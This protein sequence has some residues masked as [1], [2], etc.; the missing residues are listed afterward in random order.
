MQEILHILA[1]Y[2]GQPHLIMGDFN[3]LAPGDALHA[4]QLLRSTVR[5]KKNKLE[6]LKTHSWGKLVRVPYCDKL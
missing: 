3:S 4:S 1:A 6:M 5:K 2:Q